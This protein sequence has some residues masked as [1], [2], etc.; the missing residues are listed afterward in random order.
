MVRVPL[1]SDQVQ[2][3]QL[4]GSLL[5][6]AR[7]QRTLGD[8]ATRAGVSVETLRKIETGR[9]CTPAFATVAQ[10]AAQLGLSLDEVWSCV[11]AATAAGPVDRVS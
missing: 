10:I 3:G 7:G 6:S 5:R 1:T 2:Q 8:V 9:I 11:T 4:L